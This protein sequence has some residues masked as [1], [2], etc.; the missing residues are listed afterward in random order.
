MLTDLKAVGRI[1]SEARKKRGFKQ[2]QIAGAIGCYEPSTISM[3][4][5]GRIN[6]ARLLLWYVNNLFDSADR[7]KL[8]SIAKGVLP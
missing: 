3:F 4:E 8:D 7:E 1:C 6:N 5:N 2:Y